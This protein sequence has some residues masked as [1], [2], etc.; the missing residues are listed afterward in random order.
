RIRLPVLVLRSGES[1]PIH[2]RRTSEDVARML[3]NSR[4]IEPPWG[5]REAVDSQP[6]RRFEKWPLLAPILHEWATRA[7]PITTFLRVTWPR[8]CGRFGRGSVGFPPA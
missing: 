2:T 4:L 5:D 1:D 7:S 3:P 6:G 8:W